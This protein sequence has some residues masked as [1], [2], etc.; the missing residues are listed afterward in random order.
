MCITEQILKGALGAKYYVNDPHPFHLQSILDSFGS[1]DLKNH[2]S[3][4]INCVLGT[5]RV[6]SACKARKMLLRCDLRQTTSSSGP[7]S[8]AIF[9]RWSK[10]VVFKCQA[11]AR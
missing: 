4:N 5:I 7:L 3:V 1:K 2:K 8:S 11:T 6:I 9:R 10:S